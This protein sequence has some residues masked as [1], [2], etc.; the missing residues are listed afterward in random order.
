MVVF[1]PEQEA[2][3]AAT[4]TGSNLMIKAL[5]GTGKTST[6]ALCVA[7]Q[8]KEP[9]LALAFNV[10]NKEDL[11]K[12]FPTHFTVLS[13]NG[14]GHR[15]W[16]AAIGKNFELMEGNLAPLSAKAKANQVTMTIEQ[17]ISVRELISKA[18]NNGLVPSKWPHKSL[19]PDTAESWHQLAVDSDMEPK[20]QFLSLAR[21]TLIESIN[22]SFNGEISYDDQIYMSAMFNGQFPRFGNVIVDEAQDLSVLNHIQINRCCAGRLIVVGDPKQAIY[23]FRGA[24][25]DSMDKLRTLRQQWTDLTLSVTFRCPSVVVKRQQEHAPGYTADESNKE[26]TVLRLPIFNDTPTEEGDEEPRWRWSDVP[27]DQGPIAILCRNNAPLLKFAF[28]LIRQRVPPVMLGRDIGKNLITLA[29]TISDNN[30]QMGIS[31][32]YGALTDWKNNQFILLSANGR[33]DKIDAMLDRVDSLNAVIESAPNINVVAD[34]V[35]AII[36]LF[37]RETGKVTL[38][39]IH[40]AKGAEWPVVLLL[41]PWRIPSKFAKKKAI[42]GDE[43]E[44]KQELNLRYVA[45]TL[46]QEHSHLG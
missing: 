7:P 32:F 15:A 40:K 43:R 35:D 45:E 39:S 46:D 44:L 28:K 30:L 41:D 6:L 3:R 18:M 34:L 31:D 24:D 14:L 20:D 12:R 36:H 13:L 21:D 37:E 17:W 1:T 5:A 29:K 19:L 23:G 25:N 8:I 4:K 2:I 42:K 26:G 16:G 38:S 10:K 11:E 27:Q 22:L 33:E 9:T